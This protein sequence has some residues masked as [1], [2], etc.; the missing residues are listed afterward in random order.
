MTTLRLLV[1]LAL[2]LAVARP[3]PAGGSPDPTVGTGVPILLYHRF[4]PSRAAS[5][6]ITTPV[7]EGQLRTLHQHGY[8]VIPLRQ[9]VEWYLGQGP[10]P[11]PKSV[12]I[13][14]DDAHRSVY[15]D[16]YPLIRKY[17]VPVTLFVYPSAISNASY[18]MTW[19]QLREVKRSGLVDIQSHTYW[20]PDFR[21]ERK[22]L[23]PAAYG[24]LADSQLRRSKERLERE[25]GGTVDLLAWPY[26]MYDD[27][28]LR[29]AS[30]AGYR[31]T[32]IIARHH[33]GPGDSVLKLPRYPVLD[34]DRGNAFLQILAGRAP[35][36]SLTF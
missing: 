12:V 29:R 36:R 9:L 27:D 18:A 35:A 2:F 32:F 26:G 11:A 16:M 33:A 20:H 6:T 24:L 23:S 19:E 13:V 8:R 22:R 21:K 5:T 3:A 25:L 34:A 15:T 14:A 31:S 17:R 28:L 7:F 30:S 4:D 1:I 10:A